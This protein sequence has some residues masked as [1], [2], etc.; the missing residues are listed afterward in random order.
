[1]FSHFIFHK[2]L[3]LKS[4]ITKLIEI[5]DQRTSNT[6]KDRNASKYLFRKNISRRQ[7]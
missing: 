4:L 6:D 3:L 5:F 2:F 1:M 7:M